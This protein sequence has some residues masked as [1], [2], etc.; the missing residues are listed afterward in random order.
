MIKK[1][2]IDDNKIEANEFILTDLK[3]CEKSI[4]DLDVSIHKINL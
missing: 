4:K 3:N 2:N 1:K